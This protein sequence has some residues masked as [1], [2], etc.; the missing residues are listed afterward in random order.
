MFV[1]WIVFPLALGAV[2]IGLGLLVDALSGRRLPGALLAPAGLAAIVLIVQLV[3]LFEAAAPY[4]ASL[5]IVLAGVGLIA[6]F[7]WRFGRPDPW[8]IVAALAVFALFAAP[9]VPSG[10]P[11]FASYGELA[12]TPTWLAVADRVVEHGRSLEGLAPSSYRATLDSAL[13]GG[14]PVGAV[15]PLAAVQRLLGGEVAWHF[16]PYIAVLG[17]LLTLCAWQIAA[18]LEARGRALVAF[19]A[20]VPALVFGY[21]GWGGVQ[22]LVAVTLLALAVALGP[23]RRIPLAIVVVALL[24]VL[25]PWPPSFPFEGDVWLATAALAALVAVT[26][27]LCLWVARAQPAAA[28][29]VFAAALAACGAL[30]SANA[31]LAPHEQLTELRRVNE[32]FAEQGPALVFE[33]VPYG[34]R[35]FLRAVPPDDAAEGERSPIDT[36]QVDFR[37]LLSYPLLVLPRSPEQSR[38]PLPYRRIWLGE[39]YEVWKL[40]PTATF[41]LLFHMSIGGPRNAAALPDCSQTVGLGL[42]ALSNQLAAA[43]QD[44]SLVAASPR[45][46]DR[47]GPA[48]AVPVDRASD[49]CGRPWDWIEAIAP[50]G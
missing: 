43:P 41:R 27:A 10:S 18:S 46:G 5:A 20:A 47:L 14:E 9:V 24:A 19:L 31:S 15:L 4:A 17:A 39:E 37:A 21:A 50:A 25:A 8:P 13:A 33:R 6:S 36:D 26:V 1:A 11:T 34:S 40:P 16:Q 30:A 42:L 44:I 35:Y 12:D 22:E 2:C 7:P 49:L 32:R 38:P 28:L 23:T 45:R 3:T 29:A 48:I